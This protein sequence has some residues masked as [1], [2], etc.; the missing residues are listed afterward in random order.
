MSQHSCFG[1]LALVH[2]GKSLPLEVLRSA[3][4]HY[5]GTRDA[6]ALSRGSRP[7]IFATRPRPET[8]S[9]GAAGG[10]WT[11]RLDP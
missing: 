10:G 4:G 5:I 11:Q 7:S 8:P 2:A 1:R 9:L 3:A 6:G